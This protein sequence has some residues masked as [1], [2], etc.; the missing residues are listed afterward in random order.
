MPNAETSP[1]ESVDRA[2]VLL[3]LMHERGPV[4]VKTA[5]V[6][7]DVA[8][9]TA[10]RLLSALAFR[11]F[12]IQDRDRRYGPGPALTDRGAEPLSIKKLR[13]FA[14]G[15]LLDLN[16]RLGET[17][18]L[19]VLRGGNIQFVDGVESESMLRVGMLLGDQM[20]AFVSAG[21]KAMLAQL[22]NAELEELYRGG[23]PVWPTS[24]IT[25]MAMLKRSMTEV[26]RAEFGTNFEETEQ[27]V[28]GVGV[29]IRDGMGRPVAAVT[30]ATPSIR[31]RR[32]VM[33]EHVDALRQAAT[34][35]EE[36]LALATR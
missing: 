13:E 7:L 9:S 15:P 22:N 35:I 25:T 5:A 12:A 31:F 11:G 14:R 20:P 2:L 33:G 3:L 27:G 30:V 17:V 34:S 36:R 1:V 8:P 16:N 4:S 32:A 24:R 29:S 23:L 26:R 21:G 19:M 18:Q 6:H 10:H 28:S